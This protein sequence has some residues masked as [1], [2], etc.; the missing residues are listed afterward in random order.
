MLV[1]PLPFETVV[2][3]GSN[4]RGV[5]ALLVSVAQESFNIMVAGAV[6]GAAIHYLGA[7]QNGS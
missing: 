6:A 4:L 5:E 3:R 1:G 2:L 7:R